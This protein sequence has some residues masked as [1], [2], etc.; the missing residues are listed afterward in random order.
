LKAFRFYRSQI[1]TIRLEKEA[2]RKPHFEA[3]P[4][5]QSIASGG[6]ESGH[7]K[8]RPVRQ[9]ELVSVPEDATPVNALR[10]RAVPPKRQMELRKKA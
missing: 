9:K 10:K 7:S 5:R 3:L 2:M 8:R 6:L 4:K 1:Q